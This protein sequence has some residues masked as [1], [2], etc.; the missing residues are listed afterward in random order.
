MGLEI[1]LLAHSTGSELLEGGL[2]PITVI[3]SSV[4]WLV[5]LELES[6]PIVFVFDILFKAK[7]E[8]EAVIAVWV[9]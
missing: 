2:E 7:Y 8:A 6:E 3:F 1:A 4:S 5:K 9:F